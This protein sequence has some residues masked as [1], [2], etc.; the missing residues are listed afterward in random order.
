MDVYCGVDLG[1]SGAFVFRDMTKQ[2]TDFGAWEVL[3]MPIFT[4]AKSDGGSKSVYDARKVFHIFLERKERIRGVVFEELH[5]IPAR[6]GPGSKFAGGSQANFSMGYGLAV[7]ETVLSAL[8]IPFYKAAP[9]TW[10]KEMLKGIG[11]KTDKEAIRLRVIQQYPEL[12]PHMPNK[13]DHHVAEAVLLCHYGYQF[14]FPS[15]DGWTDP[16]TAL[17]QGA[18]TF[19]E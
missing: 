13:Q 4:V 5:A 17:R 3:R 10:K 18:D 11:R 15:L 12:H 7:V 8:E 2:R 9:Q 19:P 6:K 14:V 16:E 1:V